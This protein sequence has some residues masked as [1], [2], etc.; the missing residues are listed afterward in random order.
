MTGSGTDDF[1]KALNFIKQEKFKKAI[2]ILDLIINEYMPMTNV[3]V[4]NTFKISEWE[5]IDDISYCEKQINGKQQTFNGLLSVSLVFKI[6]GNNDRRLIFLKKALTI[7]SNNYRIWKEYAETAF[8]LGKMRNALQYFKEANNFKP[9][10]PF[11][12]EGIGLCYYYLDE[13]IKAVQPLKRSLDA[14]KNNHIVMNHLAFILS[15]LG[16]LDNAE[17]LIIDALEIEKKNNIY[18]DTYACILFLQERYNEALKIF[19]KILGNNPR[20]Y[21]VSWDILQNLYNVLGLHVKAK[22]LEEKLLL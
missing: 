13:P 11:T 8:Q 17:K 20:E 21:E 22:Q 1:K 2:N 16:E 3:V 12:L 9:D 4:K 5:Y 18:L 10:D 7:D 19:E 14:T 15:E 6:V